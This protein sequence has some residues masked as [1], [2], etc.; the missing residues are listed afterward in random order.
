MFLAIREFA[1]SKMRFFMITVIF[2]LTAWLVFILSGLGNGLS[3]LAASTF[4]NMDADYVVFEQ[5]S[6]SSM[7]KSLLSEQLAGQ[8]GQLPNVKAASPMGT[9]MAT[10]LKGESGRN[11]DKVDIAIIGII[12]G[13][14]LEPRVVEGQGLSPDQPAGVIVNT[15]LKDK[16]FRLGDRFQLDG[17][18]ESLTIVGFVQDQ[19]Y[20]HVASVFAPLSEWRKIAFAAPG[21]DKGI[22]NPVNA[23]MLQGKHIRPGD[24]EA[25]LSR[26]D[27]VTRAAAVQGLP[28]YKEENGSIM[29]MLA[30][31]LTISAF[32]L[33][34][35][36]YVMTMQKSNAFGIMKAIGATNGFLGRAI[37][38]QVFVLSLSSIVVG[39]LLTYATAAVM[40][41]EMPFQL[42]PA[43]VI[44][45][46][47]IL[48]AIALLSSLI[49]VRKMTKIDP[50]QALGRVE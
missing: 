49:S 21:S 41:I 5:G 9:S 27:T 28:G 31:L 19:T 18:T 29:M 26:T 22:S 47:I 14:F 16:G 12:P 39:I 36:F 17:S 38:S 20:N 37:V 35:F 40:P 42:N 11:E 8:A 45:Y 44:L 6:Q 50:L 15:T 48:L 30:F 33:G 13:S 7:S 43:L 3:T 2:V 24:I 46:S 23:V 34:V 1:H 25:S 32:V 10:A 4:K